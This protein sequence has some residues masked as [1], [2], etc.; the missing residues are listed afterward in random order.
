[1]SKTTLLAVLA[2]YSLTSCDDTSGKTYWHVRYEPTTPEEQ[3]AVDEQVKAIMA[4]T[5]ST[6]SGDTQD[7]QRAI[8]AATKSAKESLC[9]PTVWE[10]YAFGRWTGKWKRMEEPTKQ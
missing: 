9:K 7:W 5:P 8:E 1:M 3:R 6:L 2:L 4:K 10:S